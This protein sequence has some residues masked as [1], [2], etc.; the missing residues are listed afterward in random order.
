MVIPETLTVPLKADRDGV[1]RVGGTRVRLDTVVYA[2]NEGAIPEE[3]VSQ[4]PA[5]SLE[6]VYSVIAFYLKNQVEIDTYVKQRA[7]E[8]AE[9]R[10]RVE[11]KPRY[12]EFRKRLR[13]RKNS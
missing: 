13:S 4:Y 8:A 2:Y 7:E 3:I 10:K 9:N 5:L 1:V 12:K 6:D 11:A